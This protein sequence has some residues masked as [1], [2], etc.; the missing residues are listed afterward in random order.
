MVMMPA[1]KQ[2]MGE[3]DSPI[4]HQLTSNVNRR[5]FIKTHTAIHKYLQAFNE[6]LIKDF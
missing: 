6:F 4:P 2:E 1:I 3:L 5:N